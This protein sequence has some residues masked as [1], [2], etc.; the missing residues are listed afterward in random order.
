MRSVVALQPDVLILAESA[1]PD[2]VLRKAPDIRPSGYDWV[3]DNE[4]KGLSVFTFGSYSV[5]R[6][7][8]WRRELRYFLPV[9]V[10]GPE[11]ADILATWAFVNTTP[12]KVIPNSPLL[13]EAV[14]YYAS[15]L[16]SRG[17]VMAGDFN[18]G[19]RWD[20]DA[21]PEFMLLAKALASM[22]LSSAIHT[23]GSLPFGHRDEPATFFDRTKKDTPFHIDYVFS[24]RLPRGLGDAMN[25]AGSAITCPSLSI[26]LLTRRL[27]NQML[28]LSNA[29]LEVAAAPR[30]HLIVA[31]AA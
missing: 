16:E 26:W 4:Q 2:I 9:R 30:P 19:V 23:M 28:M 22:G 17:A 12:P 25:G 15:F 21:R 14:Q 8:T 11:N 5:A 24:L 6:A 3:G 1:R 10:T 18:A 31:L 27:P 29:V 13:G 7:P 20:S